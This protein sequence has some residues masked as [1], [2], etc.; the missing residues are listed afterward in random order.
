MNIGFIGLG[1][2]G[3]PCALAVESKGHT[4]YGY[5]IN[6]N[7]EN[8]L[9]TRKI[10]YKE[11]WA[12]DHLEKSNITFT[13]LSEVVKVIL[14]FSKWSWAHSSLYGIFLVLRIFSTFLLIS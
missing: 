9:N 13:S 2:L 4:V 12:Q 10:P 14:L 1:K 8:I 7:V 3:L 11:L 5:D 6:K